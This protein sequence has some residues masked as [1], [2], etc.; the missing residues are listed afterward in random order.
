[1]TYSYMI[2]EGPL[3]V[4]NYTATFSVLQSGEETRVVWSATFEPSGAT[5]A[6][7]VKVMKGVFDKGLEAIR[8]S[9]TK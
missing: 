3:P 7:A 1:M 9:F 5:E 2:M 6:E 8:Q 4:A